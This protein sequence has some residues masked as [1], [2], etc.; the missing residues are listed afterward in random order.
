MAPKVAVITA[1]SSGI[2]AACARDL[3]R[4]GYKVS[5]LARS[6][7]VLDLAAELGGVATL[8]SLTHD[9][10]L[11]R[12]CSTTLETFGR[13]D[14]LV[15]NAGHPAKGGLLDLSD[16]QWRDGLDMLLMP[17]IR[18][19]RL[20]TPFFEGQGGGAIVNISS[21]AAQEPSLPRPVSSVFRA[22]LSSFTKLYADQHAAKNI[23]M[24]SLLAGWVD[25]YP[26]QAADL[27]HIPMGRPAQPQEIANVVAFLLSE[28]ASYLTA[29]NLSVDGG[30][31]R[32]L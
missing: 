31:L 26:V 32:G 19:A 3:A 20:V 13:I 17:V 22:A 9:E 23:R 6:S 5:L 2:G 14:A 29:Q 30:L 4:R 16:D 24:N 28:E 27:A 11:R 25:T 8:G 12:L 7:A 10:D 21:F 1:A 18:L 15:N